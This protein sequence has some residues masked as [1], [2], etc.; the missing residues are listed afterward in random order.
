MENQIFYNNFTFDEKD[1]YLEDNLKDGMYV[2][3]DNGIDRL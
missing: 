1:E 3:T 2:R